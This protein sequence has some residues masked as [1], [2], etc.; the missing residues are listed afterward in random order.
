M[1]SKITELRRKIIPVY[2]VFFLLRTKNISFYQFI[3]KVRIFFCNYLIIS[4]EVIRK[5]NKFSTTNFYK[6]FHCVKK[7]FS[8]LKDD[9]LL[10]HMQCRLSICCLKRWCNPLNCSN[11]VVNWKKTLKP[12]CSKLSSRKMLRQ[13]MS[14]EY[15][16]FGSLWC[17]NK[18]FNVQISYLA[19]L[20]WVNV[21]MQLEFLRTKTLAPSFFCNPAVFS[22]TKQISWEKQWLLKFGFTGTKVLI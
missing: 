1:L 16:V 18:F 4:F 6:I 2:E 7:E 9:P 10:P 11:A 20:C 21:T 19:F 8:T 15:Y 12:I 22:I 5:K 13:E 14:S 17:T 3:W